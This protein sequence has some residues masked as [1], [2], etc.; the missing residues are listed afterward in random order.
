[1]THH[2]IRES[3]QKLVV[4]ILFSGLNHGREKNVTIGFVVDR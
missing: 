4:K 1:M 3:C 2:I